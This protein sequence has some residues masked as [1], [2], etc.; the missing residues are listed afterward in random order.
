MLMFPIIVIR[1]FPA[2]ETW[3][4]EAGEAASSIKIDAVDERPK[5]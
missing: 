2:K 5:E 3:C 4:S 1:I